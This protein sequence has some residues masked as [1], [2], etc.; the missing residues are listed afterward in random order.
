MMHSMMRCPH[1]GENLT[2]QKRQGGIVWHCQ[3]CLGLAATLPVLYR[4]LDRRQVRQIWHAAWETQS[5]GDVRC[6]SCSGAMSHVATAV[7]SGELLLDVCRKCHIVWFDAQE[8]ERLIREKVVAEPVAALALEARTALAKLEL[9]RLDR[10]AAREVWEGAP[11][12]ENW[13]LLPAVLGFPFEHEDRE[14]EQPPVVTWTVAVAIAISS[15]A[16]LYGSPNLLYE[17]GFIASEPVRLSGVTVLSSFLLHAGWLHLIGNLYFLIVFGDDVE[18]LLGR[19]RYLLLLAL[20]QLGALT[21]YVLFTNHGD[22]P[23][24]G[25]SG[26][27][28]GILAC[29]A[30]RLPRARIGWFFW[31]YYRF[32]I[33]QRFFS[34]PAYFAFIVWTAYQLLLAGQEYYGISP[35]AASAH[36]GGAAIGLMLGFALAPIRR[37]C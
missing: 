26:A 5:V 36:L 19:S 31:S 30:V 16:V 23:L 32:R 3:G 24:V 27:I 17:L 34:M 6:P 33:F 20:S 28:S 15:L 18:D 4:A 7:P 29:Y 14:L 2:G 35:V 1:C 9:E 22:V 21:A 11:P 10:R 13:K 8:L 25:T 37:R 12:D